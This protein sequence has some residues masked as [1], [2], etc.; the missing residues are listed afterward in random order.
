MVIALLAWAAGFKVMETAMGVKKQSVNLIRICWGRQQYGGRRKATDTGRTGV[1]SRFSTFKKGNS[2]EV[3]ERLID[4]SSVITRDVAVNPI[5]S[6]KG[7]NPRVQHHIP[8]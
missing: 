5:I 2:P 3:T 1:V 8:A 6:F 7:S 4:C